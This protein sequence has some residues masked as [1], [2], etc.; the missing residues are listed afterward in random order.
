MYPSPGYWLQSTHIKG[1]TSLL[2]GVSPQ[3]KVAFLYACDLPSW[4]RE[5]HPAAWKSF[6]VQGS[7]WLLTEDDHQSSVYIYTYLC[8]GWLSW[9]LCGSSMSFDKEQQRSSVLFLVSVILPLSTLSY[10][11]LCGHWM[12]NDWWGY[13]ICVIIAVYFDEITETVQVTPEEKSSV[14]FLIRMC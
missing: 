6:Q 11:Q 8:G 7:S 2:S 10:R 3:R 12:T 5:L 4:C 13:I 9:S 1:N 14:F